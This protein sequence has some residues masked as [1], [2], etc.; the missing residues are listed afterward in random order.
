VAAPAVSRVAALRAQVPPRRFVFLGVGGVEP[1][2][3]TR[4]AF[5]ALAALKR[6]RGQVAT[7]VV[8]GGHSF[9]DYTAY[10]DEALAALTGLGLVLGEDVVL[11]GTVTDEDLAGWYHA[12]DA[13]C[14]PSV[15]EGW[16][17]AVLEAMAADLPVLASD[18]PVF[19]E[20]LTDGVDALLPPVGDPMAIAA[21]ME[22]LLDDDGLRRK[23][24]E[25]GRAVLPQYTWAASAVRHRAIYAECLPPV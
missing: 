25:G 7:L 6:D 24:A 14:F 19:T 16:G 11:A 22:R 2:K 18:L 23:L 3:G 10:R 9:Q 12:A 15:K 1:R 5:E 4:H 8:V 13:L 17:L 20:Y 21:A